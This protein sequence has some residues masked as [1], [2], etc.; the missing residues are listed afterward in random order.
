MPKKETRASAIACNILRIFILL[1]VCLLKGT[2]CM[3]VGVEL[4]RK[5]A[6]VGFPPMFSQPKTMGLPDIPAEKRGGC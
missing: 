2:L 6:I 5:T 1:W 3:S 4:K